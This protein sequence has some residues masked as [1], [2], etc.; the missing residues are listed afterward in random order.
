MR[1]LN[2]FPVVN[3]SKE[4]ASRDLR[5]S[6]TTLTASSKEI[7][8]SSTALQIFLIIA[9]CIK[10]YFLYVYTYNIYKRQKSDLNAKCPLCIFIRRCVASGTYMVDIQ[11]F[12]PSCFHTSAFTVKV[13]ECFSK[14]HNIREII[15]II[16]CKR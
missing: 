13:P 12:K 8:L 16:A 2:L 14:I 3:L 1:C 5:S 4:H 15:N 7:H 9:S 11:V 10:L 6:L